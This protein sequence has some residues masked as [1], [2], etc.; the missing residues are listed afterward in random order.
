MDHGVVLSTLCMLNIVTAKSFQ[1]L[2][3]YVVIVIVGGNQ[4]HEST[5]SKVKIWQLLLL[6]RRS[7]KLPLGEFYW[8]VKSE[9]RRSSV[10]SY[11]SECT[12]GWRRLG[13]VGRLLFTGFVTGV[14]VRIQGTRPCFHVMP[15]AI[16]C[17]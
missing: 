15:V 10:A 6:P 9:S 16:I 4:R 13:S 12:W 11:S 8:F 5:L 7:L 1:V 14:K 17:S 3:F 2:E